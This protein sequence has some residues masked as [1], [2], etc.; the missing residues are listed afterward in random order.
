MAFDTICK[1]KKDN[2]FHSENRD[3]PQRFQIGFIL[4]I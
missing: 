2:D 4:N 3:I 1:K